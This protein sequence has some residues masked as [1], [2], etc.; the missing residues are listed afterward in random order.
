MSD[1]PDTNVPIDPAELFSLAGKVALVT[2]GSR[3]VG[4]M[5]AAGLIAA[6][7]RVIIASRDRE[8][9]E[10]A[11]AELSADGR[12]AALEADLSA[13]AGCAAL[14]RELASREPRLHILVNN[15]GATWGDALERFP[16]HGFDKVLDLNVKAL[17]FLTRELVPLLERAAA[18]GDPARVLNIGSMHG[19]VV[20]RLPNYSY[21]ASK[22]AVHH[23]TRVLAVELGPRGIAVN[24]IALGPVASRMTRQLLAEHGEEIERACPLGRIGG[25]ADVAGAAVFLASRAAAWINGAVLPVDGGL[26]L[27]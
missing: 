7:A 2:G 4:R 24:A 20:S 10:A 18:P 23:L 1:A 9:C 6:G 13:A 19:L 26:S 16:E 12:C 14:A 17:F 11:A 5:I 15:S 3:G 25:A 21:A 22:A 27:V 8:A